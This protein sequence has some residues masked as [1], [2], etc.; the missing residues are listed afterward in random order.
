[1]YKFLKEPIVRAYGEAFYEE[2]EIVDRELE[3]QNQK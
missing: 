1:V 3:K 2:M